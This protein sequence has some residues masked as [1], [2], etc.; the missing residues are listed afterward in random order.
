M[1]CQPASTMVPTAR[2][3]YALDAQKRD[4]AASADPALRRPVGRDLRG[5]ESD[6]VDVAIEV[7]LRGDRGRL[8]AQAGPW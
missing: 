3:P 4:A 2:V 8:I 6:A 5:V 1:H 7:V